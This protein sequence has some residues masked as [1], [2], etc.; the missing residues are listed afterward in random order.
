MQGSVYGFLVGSALAMLA[1]TMLCLLV[2]QC[3][4]VLRRSLTPLGIVAFAISSA[5]ATDLA[6]KSL[7]VDINRESGD[8]VPTEIAMRYGCTHTFKTIF[9]AFDF[10]NGTIFEDVDI[11]IA[12]GVYPS[13]EVPEIVMGET[14]RPLQ[15]TPYF[16]VTAIGS[17][18]SV[19]IDGG[20]VSN[21]IVS[22]GQVATPRR[23]HGLVFSNAV[24][25]A[26]GGSFSRCIATNCKI[27][28]RDSWL[29][30]CAAIRNSCVGALRCSADYCLFADN[31]G[32][33]D[34]DAAYD[35]TGVQDCDVFGSV[36]WGNRKDGQL[37]NWAGKLWGL[38]GGCNC[39]VP[40]CE[41]GGGNFC[42]DPMFVD[43]EQGDYRLKMGS[44]CINRLGW[45][46]IGEYDQMWDQSWMTDLAG[47]PRI[48]RGSADVG[49]Y[50]YQ[51]TNEHQT[52][53][54]PEP[55]EFAWID[56]KCPEV[57]EECGGDYDKAV[58]MKSANPVD[59]SLP[60]PLRTYYS[61]WESYVADL[62]PANSNQTF[63]AT[64]EMV[65]GK[66]CVKGD[67]E[68]PNRRYT[69]LGKETLADEAWKENSPDARFFKVKVG[70]K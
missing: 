43:A 48:Q 66:P 50:E 37:A 58:L 13:V 68:S 1:L 2:A 69:V 46:N 62:D 65:D 11:Y 10:L 7:Y 36:I 30:Q 5:V 44:P 56:E 59:I 3:W 25:G 6:Q 33:S 64:I 22:S 52:I 24:C 15:L 28:F 57:L 63:R 17:P 34:E 16:D 20:G 19:I 60:E 67:P 31:C 45:I 18:G 39:T 53:T 9:E 41:V 40:C 61:I 51:P 27:G 4:Q 8:F 47:Q 32:R 49:P 23:W 35:A 38:S 55:V 29:Q 26:I 14:T 54:A 70:L 21:A 12:P 42:D